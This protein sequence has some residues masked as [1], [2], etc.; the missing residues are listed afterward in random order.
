MSVEGETLQSTGLALERGQMSALQWSLSDAQPS[1]NFPHQLT[2]MYTRLEATSILLP[3]G[4]AYD[5]KKEDQGG[6]VLIRTR[7]WMKH[8]LGW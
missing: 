1:E 6:R 2:V 5:T 7:G 8:L 4:V 3:K